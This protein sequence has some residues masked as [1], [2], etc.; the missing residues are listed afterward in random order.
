M[1]QLAAA[2]G[3]RVT[4][5]STREQKGERVAKQ[6]FVSVFCSKISRCPLQC[7]MFGPPLV[8]SAL[9]LTARLLCVQEQ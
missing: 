3:S 5:V 8:L 6:A 7:S 9:L 4:V 1:R 2:T